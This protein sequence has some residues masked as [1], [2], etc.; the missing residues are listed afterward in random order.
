MNIAL[1]LLRSGS[2]SIPNKN[3]IP[4]KGRPLCDWIIKVC[5]HTDILSEVWV[6]TDSDEITDIAIKCGALVHRRH[7][8]T[9]TSTATSSSGVLDFLEMRTT[10]NDDKLE[11]VAICQATSPLTMPEHL[12]N[13]YKD[14]YKY[15]ANSVVSTIRMHLFRWT[16]HHEYYIPSNY[17]CSNRPRRQDWDGDLYEDGAFYIINIK[18][19]MNDQHI[20]PLNKVILYEM[21]Y[22]VVYDINTLEDYNMIKILVDD[23]MG[24]IPNDAFYL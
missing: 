1:I 4:L 19:F 17:I 3:I 5:Q 16:K 6:S 7:P 10:L 13:A 23:G 14:Y 18:A 15:N 24:F 11:S 21:P 2:I 22:G 12:Y 8:D 20:V 9:A